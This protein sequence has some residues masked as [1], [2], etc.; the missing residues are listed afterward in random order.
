MRRGT[1]LLIVCAAGASI[2]ACGGSLVPPERNDAASVLLDGGSALPDAAPGVAD[3]AP[4]PA[5]AITILDLAPGDGSGGIDG[6]FS[7]WIAASVAGTSCQFLLPDAPVCRNLG[8]R[9][10]V[11]IDGAKVPQDPSNGWTYT[12]ATEAS[13][14]LHGAACELANQSATGVTIRFR[15]LLP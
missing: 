13:I 2:A 14:E 15:I 8:A 4:A 6:C 11:Y 9:I 7:D 3:A 5:D 1:L 10:A 12:D